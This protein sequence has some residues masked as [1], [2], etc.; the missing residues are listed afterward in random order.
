MTRVVCK[1]V[2]SRLGDVDHQK[3]LFYLSGSAVMVIQQLPN[4]PLRG[5]RG[6]CMRSSVLLHRAT[7]SELTL[8]CVQMA[9]RQLLR[10]A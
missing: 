5:S 9:A 1:C 7:A 2:P 10:G 4:G 3:N 8:Q 6:V